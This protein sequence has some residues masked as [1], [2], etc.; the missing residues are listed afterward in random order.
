MRTMTQVGERKGFTYLDMEQDP[1]VQAYVARY[2]IKFERD[3]ILQM[4]LLIE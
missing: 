2:R 3:D 1:E 4:A